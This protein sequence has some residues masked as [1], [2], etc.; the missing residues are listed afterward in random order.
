MNLENYETQH[1][2]KLTGLKEANPKLG[3][4]VAE[5]IA[6]RPKIFEDMWW[7]FFKYVRHSSQ[8][9]LLFQ[10]IFTIQASKKKKL[11]KKEGFSL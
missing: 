2:H 11:L 1:E 5:V 10:H 4:Y 7:A 3:P 6:R 9:L 8:D